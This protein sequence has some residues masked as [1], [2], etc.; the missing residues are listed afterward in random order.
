MNEF[1]DLDVGGVE[2]AGG[3]LAI[4]NK[5]LNSVSIGTHRLAK[6]VLVEVVV[7]VES[8]APIHP[9]DSQVV[10]GCKR[11][12]CCRGGGGDAVA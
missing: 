12:G 2:V 9:K 6:V 7:C 4:Y 1:A 8:V 3:V 5:K 11:C 10:C